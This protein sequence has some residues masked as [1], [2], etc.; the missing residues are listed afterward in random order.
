MQ[1]NIFP[2]LLQDIFILISYVLRVKSTRL[3]FDLFLLFSI[4]FRFLQTK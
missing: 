2:N 4:V 3:V 1:K